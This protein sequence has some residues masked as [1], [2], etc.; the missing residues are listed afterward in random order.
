M[1]WDKKRETIV[2]NESSDIIRMFNSAFD[3]LGASKGDY[4]PRRLREEIDAL[5]ARIYKTLNNGVYKAGFA[6][7]QE[8]YDEAIGPLF[9]TLDW[10]DRRLATQRYLTGDRVTEADWRLFP[11][12]LRFDP[13]Y[14]VHF[15]CSR[16]RIRDYANLWPYLLD[17]YQHPGIAETVRMDHIRRH[18]YCSHETI[19]P[20]GIVAVEPQ[21][22]LTAP[23]RRERLAA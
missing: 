10:L 6:T 1:L 17:L 22:D 21:M 14:S 23:T 5:N 19:N 8:A 20:N 4:Y 2:N 3:H 18:Y 11:T 9:E 12:L 16:R 13:V 15:K 7:S